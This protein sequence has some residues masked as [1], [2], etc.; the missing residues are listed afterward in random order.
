MRHAATPRARLH[1]DSFCPRSTRPAPLGYCPA[2]AERPCVLF[3][4][5]HNAARSQLAEA[6]LRHHAGD[7]F[8]ACSASMEPTD[9]HPMT[10]RVL[11][12]AGIDTSTLRSKA[13]A[14][15]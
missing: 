8:R 9:V 14:E 13:V 7:R 2:M 11:E 3:L 4:C 5:T 6:L 12:E 10:R 15:K 1:S